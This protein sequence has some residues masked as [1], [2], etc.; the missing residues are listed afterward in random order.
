MCFSLQQPPALAPI[1]LQLPATSTMA[2]N[3]RARVQYTTLFSVNMTPPLVWPHK[4]PVVSEETLSSYTD[5]PYQCPTIRIL[6]HH[7]GVLITE[8]GTK[9]MSSSMNTSEMLT[10]TT[11]SFL[12]STSN[13]LS[14]YNV[15]SG[16]ELMK[17]LNNKTYKEKQSS[18]DPNVSG[19]SNRN[20]SACGGRSKET[21]VAS[22]TSASEELEKFSQLSLSR[23]GKHKCALCMLLCEQIN[24][25]FGSK[26]GGR[27]FD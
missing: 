12:S 10:H 4:N 23:K 7:E 18:Q 20:D 1:S 13:T 3:N 25:V 27:F 26:N 2:W 15:W 8:F 16:W 9:E 19:K 5:N 11:H 17:P 6:S 24:E 14:T 21:L 22:G